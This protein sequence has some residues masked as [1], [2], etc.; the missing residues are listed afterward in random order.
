MRCVW[1]NCRVLALFH[2]MPCSLASVSEHAQKSATLVP[3]LL[4]RA[5]FPCLC[6][7]PQL[8]HPCIDVAV[9]CA[10]DFGDG[11]QWYLSAV[12]RARVVNEGSGDVQCRGSLCQ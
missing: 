6:F 9:H 3:F 7:F 1:K 8:Q 12:G 2:M 10:A 11:I 4:T 5:L